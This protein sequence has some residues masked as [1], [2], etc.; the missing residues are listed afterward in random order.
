MN[1]IFKWQDERVDC[2][3]LRIRV[4]CDKYSKQ[5]RI[6]KKG[7]FALAGIGFVYTTIFPIELNE[8]KLWCNACILHFVIRNAIIRK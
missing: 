2:R 7:R 4:V 5:E 3:V 8:G 6:L 1:P